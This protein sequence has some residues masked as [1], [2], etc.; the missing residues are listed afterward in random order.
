M[1]LRDTPFRTDHRRFV[2]ADRAMAV[3]R[4]QRAL[5]DGRPVTGEHVL[6]RTFLL[7]D[8]VVQ[9]HALPTHGLHRREVVRHE[10]EGGALCSTSR[11]LSEA[12][13]LEPG[14]ADGEHFVDEQDVGLEERGDGEP[15]AHLHARRIELDLSVDRVL[16]LGELDDVVEAS[17]SPPDGRGRATCRT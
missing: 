7:D 5:L 8:S 16:E 12:L 15:E 10:H 9:P 14:V 11:I 6:D 17:C 13:L 1:T 2:E 3:L 4:D